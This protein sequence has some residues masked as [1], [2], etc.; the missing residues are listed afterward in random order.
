M[1]TDNHSYKM[2]IRVLYNIL[3]VRL[4]IRKVLPT[5]AIRRVEV[6]DCGEPLQPL[7]ADDFL[8]LDKGSIIYGRSGVIAKLYEVEKFLNSHGCRLGIYEIYRDEAAQLYKRNNEYDN[9]K[10]ERPELNETD[11]RRILDS[12][13]ANITKDDIGGHQTGGAIDCTLCSTDGQSLDMGTRYAEFSDKTKTHGSGLSEEQKRNRDLLCDAMRNAGF[14]NYPNEWWH[15]SYGDKMWAAYKHRRV[16]IY[17]HG[18]L[19]NNDNN[20]NKTNRL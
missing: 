15:F 16:A 17:G 13:V 5:E 4:R 10:K 12:R 8:I 3:L 1:T 14:V 18:A 9:L 20:N 6:V 11:I 7:P 19:H 2:T